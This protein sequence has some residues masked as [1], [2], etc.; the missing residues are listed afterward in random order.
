MHTGP[1]GM[2]GGS[3]AKEGFT[4]YEW[5]M[6]FHSIVLYIQF[7]S[8]NTISLCFVFVTIVLFIRVVVGIILVSRSPQNSSL[9]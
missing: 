6:D 9:F 1:Q 8:I 2:N 5:D 7:N 4:A 3:Q